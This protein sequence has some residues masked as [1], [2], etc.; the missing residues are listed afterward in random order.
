MKCPM[1]SNE[2]PDKSLVGPWTVTF[3]SGEKVEICGRCFLL[4]SILDT[5]KEL[6]DEH[7]RR[8]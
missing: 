3:K 5:L 2:I 1:C 6:K 4:T 8:P 7:N